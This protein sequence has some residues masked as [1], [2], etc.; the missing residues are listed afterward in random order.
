MFQKGRS[1]AKGSG[2]PAQAEAIQGPFKNLGKGLC[3]GEDWNL[4][5]SWP[6]DGKQQSVENCGVKCESTP[7]C[8]AFDVSNYNARTKKYQCWLHGNKNPEPASG[9]DGTCY[10]L[11]HGSDE[12]QGGPGLIKIG[13]SIITYHKIASTNKSRLEAQVGFFRLLV[14]GIF[15]PYVL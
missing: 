13:K 2:H 7:G 1:S 3:R 10:K 14:K 11:S 15:G 6:Q 8:N 9:L 12:S 4:D 5:D